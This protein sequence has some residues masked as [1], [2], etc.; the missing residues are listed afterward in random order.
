MGS[1]CTTALTIK[2]R[3]GTFLS[4]QPLC[5][6]ADTIQYSPFIPVFKSHGNCFLF[7]AEL[8]L[9]IPA[10]SAMEITVCALL[11]LPSTCTVCSSLR[12]W[13]ALPSRVYH[14][15]EMCCTPFTHCPA[16]ITLKETCVCDGSPQ[17]LLPPSLLDIVHLNFILF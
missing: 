6:S 1:L 8:C 9:Q 13:V 10:A 2:I 17:G 14:G 15:L 7:G 4:D 11:Q 16:T 3:R 12:Y 5:Y